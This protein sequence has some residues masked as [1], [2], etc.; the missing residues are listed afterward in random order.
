M[1]HSEDMGDFSTTQEWTTRDGIKTCESSQESIVTINATE[2]IS[3]TSFESKMIAFF[4]QRGADHPFLNLEHPYHML[5]CDK[6]YKFDDP[7]E[8]LSNTLILTACLYMYFHQHDAVP[9]KLCFI[10]P[11]HF[12]VQQAQLMQQRYLYHFSQ[13]T[14]AT[15]SPINVHA[16][17]FPIVVPGGYGYAEAVNQADILVMHG[18]DYTAKYVPTTWHGITWIHIFKDTHVPVDPVPVSSCYYDY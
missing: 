1:N 6:N 3:L 18:L 12:Y 11:T 2:P 7:T 15:N 9:K 14:S 4:D 8:R 10:S 16:L 13:T 5:T 17:H